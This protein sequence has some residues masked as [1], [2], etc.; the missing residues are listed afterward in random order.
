MENPPQARKRDKLKGKLKTA[1]RRATDPTAAQ[2][3]AIS[4][5]EAAEPKSTAVSQSSKMVKRT[6][7]ETESTQPESLWNTALSR[8]E[9]SS[10]VDD[11]NRAQALRDYVADRGVTWSSGDIIEE[12][13]LAAEAKQDTA[14]QKA[15]KI[16]LGPRTVALRE[17]AARLV[18]CLNKFKEIGDL[19]V[20][21]DPVHAALPWAAFRL[22]LQVATLSMEQEGQILMAMDAV[23]HAYVRACATNVCISVSG[24]E[25]MLQT[26]SRKA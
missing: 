16:K 26:P 4:K 6:T 22:I 13:R 15:W 25:V 10:S 8:L 1:F 20:Q 11:R 5:N 19:A 21:Y 2:P 12:L 3:P 17:V 24:K 23:I 14:Q 7:A 9:C 18:D